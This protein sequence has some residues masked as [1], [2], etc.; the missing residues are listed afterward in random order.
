MN[1]DTISILRI[2]GSTKKWYRLI[3]RRLFLCNLIQDIAATCGVQWFTCENMMPI[4]SR[5]LCVGPKHYRAKMESQYHEEICPTFVKILNDICVWHLFISIWS[6]VVY[7]KERQFD[8]SPNTTGTDGAIP[9]VVGNDKF[10]VGRSPKRERFVVVFGEMDG[11][12]PTISRFS[13]V[14]WREWRSVRI[15]SFFYGCIEARVLTECHGKLSVEPS[16]KSTKSDTLIF[17]NVLSSFGCLPSFRSRLHRCPMSRYW[18]KL[19][20]SP[21]MSTSRFLCSCL[22]AFCSCDLFGCILKKINVFDDSLSSGWILHK[23]FRTLPIPQFYEKSEL[24]TSLSSFLSHTGHVLRRTHFKVCSSLTCHDGRWILYQ[25]E[26]TILNTFFD[27]LDIVR[28]L[29]LAGVDDF[30]C[31]FDTNVEVVIRK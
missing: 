29:R 25:I 12:W 28:R 7:Y 31:V 19:R 18:S 2:G 3:L 5:N 10:G 22:L 27:I 21:F 13:R 26:T 1:R 30:E 6:V 15:L 17:S 9:V 11:R 23:L 8:R 16:A 20:R 24:L 4:S 14:N